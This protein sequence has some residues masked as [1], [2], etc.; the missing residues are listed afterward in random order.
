MA[1]PQETEQRIN[2]HIATY[3]QQ[4][5]ARAED[6]AQTADLAHHLAGNLN[7]RRGDPL[8]DYPHD[9]SDS[10]QTDLLA[11]RQPVHRGAQG[12][13]LQRHMRDALLSEHVPTGGEDRRPLFQ[14]F[15]DEMRR[16]GNPFR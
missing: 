6:A 13:W 8:H 5:I 2:A 3:E 12:F 11:G 10:L 4:V 15:D 9:G 16:K 7:P 14:R 1:N